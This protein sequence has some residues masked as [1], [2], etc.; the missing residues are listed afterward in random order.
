MRAAV[1]ALYCNPP[2]ARTTIP[3]N[4][5]FRPIFRDHGTLFVVPSIVLILPSAFRHL[6]CII[7]GT[8]KSGSSISAP[9]KPRT[10]GARYGM[11]R[12]DYTK[13]YYIG[14]HRGE[15]NKFIDDYSGFLKALL[16]NMA[17][18]FPPRSP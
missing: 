14:E 18:L 16:S 11:N 15:G 9:P 1:D 12:C 17:W 6:L 8:S 5:I 7:L 10:N 2:R 13:S 4:S 3:T